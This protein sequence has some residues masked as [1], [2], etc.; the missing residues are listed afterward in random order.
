[1]HI[2]G[3]FLHK[4]YEILCRKDW[5]MCIKN[6]MQKIFCAMHL[7]GCKINLKDVYL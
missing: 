1:M 2:C 7:L 5:L 4:K 3:L 6:Y